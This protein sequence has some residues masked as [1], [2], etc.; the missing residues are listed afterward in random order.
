MLG[1]RTLSRGRPR[2]RI[3]PRGAESSHQGYVAVKS[4]KRTPHHPSPRLSP[5]GGTCHVFVF[6]RLVKHHLGQVVRP[7]WALM[8]PVL[9][10]A[11]LVYQ[12]LAPLL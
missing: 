3:A 8:D 7:G 10:T 12:R 9:A 2:A 6:F 5:P 1:S 4:K 11:G